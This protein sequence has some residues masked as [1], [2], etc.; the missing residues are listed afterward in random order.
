MLLIG[1]AW[2]AADAAGGDPDADAGAG[3]GAGADPAEVDA[4]AV[5]SVRYVALAPRVET[6]VAVGRKIVSWFGS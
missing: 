1:W 5:S 2:A 6:T 4:D 3:A